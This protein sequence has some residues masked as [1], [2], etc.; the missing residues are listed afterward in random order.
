ME[1]G[2]GLRYWF[3]CSTLLIL[4]ISHLQM[5]SDHQGKS[6]FEEGWSETFASSGPRCN[7]GGISFEMAGNR[8]YRLPDK[9]GFDGQVR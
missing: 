7:F 1:C 8:I 3:I 2:R 5:S 4:C 9:T 6:L